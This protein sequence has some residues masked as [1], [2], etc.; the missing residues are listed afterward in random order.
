M[1]N[2]HVR[3]PTPASTHACL[4]CTP[5]IKTYNSIMVMSTFISIFGHLLTPSDL[6]NVRGH[7]DIHRRARREI[8]P[9]FPTFTRHPGIGRGGWLTQ[10]VVELR[11]PAEASK[12]PAMVLPVCVGEVRQRPR[13]DQ[14]GLWMYVHGCV[15][16]HTAMFEQ[17]WVEMNKSRD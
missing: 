3:N 11:P 5:I 8:S 13:P 12:C 15:W 7:I 9:V 1:R 4:L 10:W 16:I 6:S 14:K 17:V 2:R